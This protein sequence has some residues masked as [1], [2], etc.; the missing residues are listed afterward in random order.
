MAKL[1]DFKNPL[2]AKEGSIFSLS[3]WTGGILWVVM[4]GMILAIGVT[5]TNK[6]DAILPGN[7]SPNIK[8]YTKVEQSGGVTML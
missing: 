5:L 2:T 3:T 1:T 7:Q 4:V 6:L 8:P